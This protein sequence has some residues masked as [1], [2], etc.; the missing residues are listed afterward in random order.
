[1]KVKLLGTSGTWRDIANSARTTIGLEAGDKEVSSEWKKRMLLCE[2]SPIRKLKV[3]WKWKE[4]P[5]WVSTHFVRHKYGVEHWVSTQR[6][7]RKGIDRNLLQQDSEV[8]H[9]AEANAQAI[10]S[11]SRRRLCQCA[12]VETRTAWLEFLGTLVASEP[13]LYAV[14][15]PDCVYRGHC[16][17]YTTCGYSETPA[18]QKQLEKYR[19]V[20]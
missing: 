6:T 8:I 15:V 3:S 7:D 9:E 5:Y 17:E 1:M 11:I 4:L 13:E 12:S 19:R 18:Y 14:C 16:Y 10:I 20:K 2:H